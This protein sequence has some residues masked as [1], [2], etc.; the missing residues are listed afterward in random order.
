M[1]KRV[2]ILGS[3]G[4]VGENALRVI[5]E[6]R[7]QC[8]VVGLAA[9]TNIERLQEQLETWQPP[10]VVVW[11]EA[12]AAELRRRVAGQSVRVCSGTDGLRALVTDPACD[13]VVAAMSGVVGLE[14]LLA[15]L[16]ARKTVALANKEPL[17]MAGELVMATARASGAHLIPVDSEHSAL[18]QCLETVQR[19]A[20]ARLYITGS[21]GPLKDLAVGELATVERSSVLNHPRWKMGP[22]ITVDSATLM[23]KGLELIEA[24]WLFDMPLERLTILIHPEAA[25]HAMVELCDGTLLSVVATCDMRLPI[26]YALSYPERWPSAA[27]RLQWTQPQAWHFEPPDLTKFPCLRLASDAARQGGTIPAV[28]NAANEV[29]VQAYLRGDLA[30]PDIAQLIAHVVAAATPAPAQSLEAILAA[31]RWARMTAEH[32]LATERRKPMMVLQQ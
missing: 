17:V 15:A 24:H 13:I 4:S 29:A 14:P 8:E 16:A 11:D 19:A 27:P 31:D 21:G 26:Q 2:T 10:G 20:V 5:A 12:K 32:W 25:V 22:K 23:N 18:F 30:F 6:H 7:E 28:L 3:T 9:H 1:R